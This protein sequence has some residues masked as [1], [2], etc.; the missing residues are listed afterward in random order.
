MMP[1]LK[2][3]ILKEVRNLKQAKKIDSIED[4]VITIAP[5]Q[6]LEPLPQGSKYLGFIFARGNTPEIVEEAI[7]EAY[8][9]LDVIVNPN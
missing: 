5:E 4:I 7:R 1:V 6:K 3:G 2:T 8:N 9:K